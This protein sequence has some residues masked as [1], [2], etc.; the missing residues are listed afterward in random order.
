MSLNAIIGFI[1]DMG[2][3]KTLLMSIFALKAVSITK[4]MIYTNYELNFSKVIGD[5][6]IEY[7]NKDFLKSF[8]S[9]EGKAF[10][11]VYNTILLIDEISAFIDSYTQMSKKAQIFS[12]FVLQSRKRNVTIMYTAQFMN[13]I[14]LRIRKVTNRIV[15][16]T[17]DDKKDV[18]E[19]D[20]YKYDGSVMTLMSSLYIP[21]ASRYFDI[22]N[23]DIVIDLLDE[24]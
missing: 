14:P 24:M 22:Y 6:E 11:T 2:A 5:V 17:Y 1:G 23:T 4:S 7:M 9:K 21:Q 10:K 13:L 20:V 3:G 19:Y 12:K 16:P 8:F 18:L 15:M